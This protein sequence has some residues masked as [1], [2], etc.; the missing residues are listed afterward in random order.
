MSTIHP[1]TFTSDEPNQAANEAPMEAE[2]TIIEVNHEI[3]FEPPVILEHLGEVMEAMYATLEDPDVTDFMINQHDRV[4]IEKFGK[5]QPTR[6]VLASTELVFQ[7]AKILAEAT[8]KAAALRDNFSLEGMLPEGHRIT[9]I[10]PPAALHCPSISIRTFPKE[11][12]TLDHMVD[13]GQMT[14]QMAVFLK[15]AVAHRTNVIIAGNTSSGKTTLLNAL[16]AHIDIKDRVVTIEDTPEIRAQ[17]DNVVRLEINDV[18]EKRGPNYASARDLLRCT[19]RIRPDRIIMGEIR[20][21]EAFDLLQ[22]INTGHKGSM[23]T[24]HANTS[25]EALA[26]LEHMVSMANPDIPISHI[27]Q[28]IAGSLNLLIQTLR[29]HD[30]HR[31]ITH[32]TELVGMEG[33]VFLTHDHFVYKRDAWGNQRHHWL[34]GNSRNLAVKEALEAASEVKGTR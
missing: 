1:V 23:S 33:D 10:M 18:G 6:F 29:D 3:E 7:L 16:T 30:G 9:I 8:G 15:T 20:G 32:I 22:A 27:R 12:V 2:K 26:R 25:R 21:A 17:R 13:G 34:Y 14:T 4:F 31:R 19:L 11:L 28:H 24:M 5:M